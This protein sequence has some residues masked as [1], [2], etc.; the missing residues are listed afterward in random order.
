MKKP[1]Q[2]KKVPAK[3]S[4]TAKSA[5]PKPA[6]SKK[7]AAPKK[8]AAAKT[9]SKTLAANEASTRIAK[10]VVAALENLKAK[11]VVTIDVR[12]LTDVMDTL[13]IASGTSNR[14]VKSLA[15]NARVELKKN[16][17]KVYGSEGEDGG[18]WVLVDFGSVV[19]HAMQPHIREFYDLERLWAMPAPQ[20]DHE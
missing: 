13:V 9:A 18:E 1:A 14:H 5:S 10:L 15:D 3:K 16:G 20:P 17:Y 6:A 2:P 4:A 19:L 11:N 8:P 12:K 7:M